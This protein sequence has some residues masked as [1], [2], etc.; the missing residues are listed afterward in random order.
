MGATRRMDNEPMTKKANPLALVTGGGGFLGAA[1]VRMLVQ[2]GDRVRCLARSHYPELETLGVEQIQGD[3]TDPD[4]VT[5]A[6]AGVDTVYHV[7]AKAGIWGRYEDFF[8]ANVIGTCNV[9]AACNT[10]QVQRLIYTSSPSAIFNGED[11]ENVD[12]SVPY[13]SEFHHHYPKTKAMAEQAVRQA[14]AEG[15]LAVIL[16]PHLIWGPGDPHMVP[17]LLD[18]ANRLR[19]IGNGNQRVDTIYIDNAAEA[20][21]LAEEAL[22]NNPAVSGRVYFISQDQPVPLWQMIDW[23]L[24]AG[25]KP[26]VRKTMSPGTAFAIGAICEKIYGMFNLKGEPPMTR[27]VAKEMATSHWFN[28]EAAKRDLGYT[29][30]VS[31]EEGLKRLRYWLSSEK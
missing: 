4:T 21:L 29:P 30:K 28:I 14:A 19:R 22:R 26:P 8:R 15:L 17:R 24:A 3:L 6:C 10:Q 2:R 12:E 25:G 20:H 13:P 23:I 11:M 9:I 7:A 31:I 5:A 27:F 18:R 16:R 1:I